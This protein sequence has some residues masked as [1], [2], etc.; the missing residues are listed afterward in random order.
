MITW[1]IVGNSHDA[2]VAVFEEG[3]FQDSKCLWAGLSKDFS[4]IE[5]DPHLNEMLKKVN[6][7]DFNNLEKIHPVS[8]THLTLPTKRIV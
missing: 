3:P 2:S 6:D 1:G 8:Y 5:N 7:D 4:G